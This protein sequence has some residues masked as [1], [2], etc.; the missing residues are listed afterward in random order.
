M[1]KAL[2][3][4][5][6]L[7]L[8]L[9]NAAHCADIKGELG[10]ALDSELG[11]YEISFAKCGAATVVR[12]YKFRAREMTFHVLA[13]EESGCRAELEIIRNIA[14]DKAGRYIESKYAVIRDLYE[15]KAIPYSGAVTHDTE[16]PADMKPARISLEIL[17][18]PVQALLA[19]ASERYTLGVWEKGSVRK[20]AGFIAFYDEP[21][22]ILFQVLV[23]AD[24]DKAAAGR[25]TGILS[26]IRRAEPVK[27]DPI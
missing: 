24:A 9:L 20:K 22:R 6:A 3:A 1:K 7:F 23:F 14:P 8:S 10:L 17:G 5:P 25:I 15:P 19:N 16:C 13:G 2:I 4:A 26:G 18:R 21:A 11:Q 12:N 27:K